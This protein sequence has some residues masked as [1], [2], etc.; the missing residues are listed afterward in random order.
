MDDHI[1]TQAKS[2]ADVIGLLRR[3]S[4]TPTSQRVEIGYFLFARR[5]HVTAECLMEQVNE[6]PNT[7]SKATV[8]NTLS[9]FADK[10]L[11]REVVVD[12]TKRF[13]DTNLRPH[14]HIY[15]TDSGV[16]KDIEAE[17]I[18]IS[19]LPALPADAVIDG[20]DV[21]VRAHNR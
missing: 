21:I 12:P 15:Y 1:H 3:N 20:V 18:Q 19:G 7:V 9:V 14:H 17:D 11:I 16:L 4:I 6:G 5:Q 13:Y 2:R 8:Y 10:G